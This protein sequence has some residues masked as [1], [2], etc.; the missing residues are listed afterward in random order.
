MSVTRELEEYKLYLGVYRRLDVTMRSL[1][2]KRIIFFST[3]K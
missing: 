1:E 3:G 2:E